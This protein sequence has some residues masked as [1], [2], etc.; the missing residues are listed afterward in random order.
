MREREKRGWQ[1]DLAMFSAVK[2]A[3]TRCVRHKSLS[4][5]D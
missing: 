2:D 1:E 4:D 3:S 5:K